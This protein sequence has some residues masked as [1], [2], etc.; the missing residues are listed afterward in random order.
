MLILLFSCFGIGVVIG[1][2]VDL[3]VG[4]CFWLR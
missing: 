4:V 3:V 1:V 2:S